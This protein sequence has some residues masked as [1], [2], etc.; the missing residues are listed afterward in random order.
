MT[1]PGALRLRLKLVVAQSY[2]VTVT[3][4]LSRCSIAALYLRLFPNKRSRQASI[5]MLVYFSALGLSVMI[6]NLF[7]CRPISVFWDLAAEN[8]KCFNIFL[9]FELTCI[10]NIVG[11]VSMMLIPVP[12]VWKLQTSTSRKVGI[13]IVFLSGSM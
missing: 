5:L 11:D 13:A 7:Q 12:T 6:A 8:A 2:L 9:F 10:S 3:S 4:T 1:N